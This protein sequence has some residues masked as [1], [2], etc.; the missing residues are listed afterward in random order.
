MPLASNKKTAI[1]IV[2]LIEKKIIRNGIPKKVLSGNGNGGGTKFL[3]DESFLK[4]KLFGA[5]RGKLP[6]DTM[7]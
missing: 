2:L 4:I 7:N 1:D 5:A 3:T 6:G